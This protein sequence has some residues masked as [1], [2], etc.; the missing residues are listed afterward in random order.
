MSQRSNCTKR[1]DR[2]SYTAMIHLS[3]N[4]LGPREEQAVLGP[5]RS[6]RLVQGPEVEAFEAAVGARLGAAYALA[7]SSGNFIRSFP[8][9]S[10]R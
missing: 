9:S 1:F 8:Y 4:C 5:L 10:F 3:S 6:G 2:E 7:T